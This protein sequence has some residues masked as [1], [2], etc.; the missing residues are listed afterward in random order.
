MLADLAHDVTVV[1]LSERVAATSRSQRLRRQMLTYAGAFLAVVAVGAGTIIATANRQPSETPATAPPSTSAPPSAVTS[2]AAPTATPS[3]LSAPSVTAAPGIVF[4]LL[5]GVS[6][7]YLGENGVY[8]L[9][10]DGPREV[11]YR[12]I[13]GRCGLAVSPDGTRLV[14]GTGGGGDLVVANLD[15]SGA[16]TVASGVDCGNRQLPVWSPDGQ[17][18]LFYPQG[19]TQRKQVVV[20]TGAVSNTPFADAVHLAFSPNGQFAAYEQD[21][22]I[23]VARAG[24][25]S[26][27]RRT[28]HHDE[29]AGPGFSV[30]GISDD[31]RYAVAGVDA[32]DPGILRS[33]HQVVDTVTGADIALPRA[34]GTNVYAIAVYPLPGG[35]WLVRRDSEVELTI[36]SAQAQEL[37][38]AAEL[39][40]MSQ[41]GW[42]WTVPT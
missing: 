20:A 35:N 14:W 31:G 27:V 26:V 34:G 22:E 6:L 21:G 17:R 18:L 38:S 8:I 36:V 40:E 4:P 5:S 32:N 28:A 12:G 19:A 25:G 29:P 16:R 7:Y 11:P 30:Q 33:G 3:V 10:A 1:D 41:I 37:G 13:V 15:G 24:D 23:V 39:V 42:L 9:G 2:S